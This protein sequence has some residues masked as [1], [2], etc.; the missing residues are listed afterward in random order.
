MFHN[1][2][3]S[4]LNKQFQEFD[5]LKENEIKL[6]VK[7]NEIIDKMTFLISLFIN[8]LETYLCPMVYVCLC[9]NNVPL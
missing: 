4:A 1:K 3:H 9:M 5:K 2:K 7:D 8:P 6:H